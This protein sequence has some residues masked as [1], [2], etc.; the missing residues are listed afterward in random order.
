MV[1]GH[2]PRC[3]G[4]SHLL[5][6]CFG[7]TFVN[8]YCFVM[9]CVYWYICLLFGMYV[10]YINDFVNWFCMY[11]HMIVIS[12]LTDRQVCMRAKTCKWLLVYVSMNIYSYIF[13]Y[14]E[15]NTYLLQRLAELTVV[16]KL[17]KNKVSVSPTISSFSF[18]KVLPC[19]SFLQCYPWLPFLRHVLG[20]VSDFPK[21]Y[22]QQK[23]I[24]QGVRVTISHQ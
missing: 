24:I 6:G 1:G 5:P 4:K 21:V 20:T 11:L 14:V 16:V 9:F 15:I 10:L 13:I 7:I 8:T 18:G 23:K 3:P 17:F 22:L 12:S 2:F 19:L